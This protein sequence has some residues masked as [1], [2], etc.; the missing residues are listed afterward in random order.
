MPNILEDK[1][2]IVTGSGRGVGRGVAMLM[3]QEGAQVVVVDPGVN[4][5]GSGFDQ[6]VA[7][8]VA[9]EINQSGGSAVACTESV[10]TM[11]GGEAIVQAA[12]D[13]L[14]QA[15]YSRDLRRHPAG[16]HGVQHDRT[17]MG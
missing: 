1:V 11:E 17:G 7:Q 15:G 2:A 10:A 6:S 13:I 9:D 12:I 8:V 4:V 3:A 16:P 14:R 5:D